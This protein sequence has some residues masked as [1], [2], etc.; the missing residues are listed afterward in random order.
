ML[1]FG[2][3]ENYLLSLVVLSLSGAFDSI[4]V[5]IRSSA[6]QLVSP[7]QM[8]GKISAINAIFIGSS[9]E[10]GEFESGVAARFLGTVPAVVVGAVAC[11]ATVVVLGIRSPQLWR[12][13]LRQLE[14]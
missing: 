9:N 7:D 1:V 2:L 5:V 13:D 14:R 11:L 12:L 3:S 10:L 4:S 6:V 8:R